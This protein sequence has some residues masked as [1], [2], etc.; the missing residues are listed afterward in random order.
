MKKNEGVNERMRKRKRKNY[1][2]N[3]KSDKSHYNPALIKKQKEFY[4]NAK[5]VKKFKK[6]LKHQTEQSDHFSTQ[7]LMIEN[8]SAEMKEDKCESERRR[9]KKYCLEELYRKKHEEKERERMEREAAMMAKKEEREEAQARRK[10]LRDKMLKKTRKG[11]P[12]MKYRIEHLLST[13]QA[14][15]QI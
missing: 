5:N 1:S 2:V 15:S 11:Q 13:I 10:A 9:K 8:S 12:L 7:K 3:L 6:M 14:S 4:K